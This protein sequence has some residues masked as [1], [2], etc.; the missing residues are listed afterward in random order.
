MCHCFVSAAKNIC[1]Y[2]ENVKMIHTSIISYTCQRLPTF[3]SL[4]HLHGF[5]C[6]HSQISHICRLYFRLG[7]V[8]CMAQHLHVVKSALSQSTHLC[9]LTIGQVR[10]PTLL[11][12]YMWL[13][14]LFLK[15][16][17]Q[18]AF[19]LDYASSRIIIKLKIAGS[20]VY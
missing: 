13:N 10:S 4:I 17:M 12:T 11:N 18:V 14:D 8:P 20:G 5:K 19:A 3:P 7:Q 1:I 9:G 2:Y 15:S 16:D 6:S